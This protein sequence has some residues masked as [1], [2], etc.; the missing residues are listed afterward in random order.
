MKLGRSFLKAKWDYRNYGIC[1]L[2]SDS[3]HIDI[4]MSGTDKWLPIP[5]LSKDKFNTFF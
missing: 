4:L 2:H 1:Q 3:N 5:L